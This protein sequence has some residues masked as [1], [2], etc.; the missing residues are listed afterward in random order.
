MN[1]LNVEFSIFQAIAT[2]RLYIKN[3]A[4]QMGY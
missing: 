2:I 4:F 3:S 1:S